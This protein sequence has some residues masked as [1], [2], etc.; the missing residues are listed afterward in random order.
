MKHITPVSNHSL[1]GRRDWQG[2]SRVILAKSSVAQFL[3]SA[4][5]SML[6]FAGGTIV[7][8]LQTVPSLEVM[9][10][11]GRMHTLATR[12]VTVGFVIAGRAHELS[13]HS[14]QFGVHGIECKFFVNLSVLAV[15]KT[16]F[17]MAAALMRIFQP[18]ATS[19]GQKYLP[20]SGRRGFQYYCS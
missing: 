10:Y 20:R 12:I 5:F 17:K 9:D 7:S 13:W 2:I 16:N 19:I 8:G 18:N 1:W 3:A 4:R 14:D 15:S 6:Y 11:S